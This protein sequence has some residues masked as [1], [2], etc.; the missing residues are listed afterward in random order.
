MLDKD[1]FR[2]GKSDIGES[3]RNSLFQFLRHQIVSLQNLGGESM[4]KLSKTF[5]LRSGACFCSESFSK[6]HNHEVCILKWFKLVDETAAVAALP[7]AFWKNHQE[8]SCQMFSSYS[9]SRSLSQISSGYMTRF[10]HTDFAR[11]T[12]QRIC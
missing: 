11:S 9:F 1:K 6:P 12:P 3:E 5:F 2:S 10:A 8:C 4:K 7:N